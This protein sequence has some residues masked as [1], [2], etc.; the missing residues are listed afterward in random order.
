MKN[1]DQTSGLRQVVKGYVCL[2]RRI[3]L[4]SIKSR[5]MKPIDLGY[6]IIFLISTD[7]DSDPNRFGFIRHEINQ[8]A[9]I[10]NIPYSTL[11]QHLKALIE[12]G[13]IVND[14]KMPKIL[15]FNLFTSSGAQDSSSIKLSDE[16]LKNI[17]PNL[18]HDYVIQEK[19]QSISPFSFS[20]SFKSE[21]NI[22]DEKGG[23]TDEF[24]KE[25]DESICNAT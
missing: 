4:E 16:D 22:H 21:L 24:A 17:F 14:R 3:I 5:K 15:E 18:L 25:V 8:L 12:K 13:F 1:L 11:E 23:Y 19:P 6:F 2:P 7:W 9:K 20:S 10:W